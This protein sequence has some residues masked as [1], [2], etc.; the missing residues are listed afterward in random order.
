MQYYSLNAA[1]L[2]AAIVVSAV[3]GIGVYLLVV[4][5][6]SWILRHERRIDAGGR[7]TMD[8]AASQAAG[9]PVVE[10]SGVSKVFAASGQG[11]RPR[12]GPRRHRPVRARR[13]VH[14][15]DRAVGLRQVH[16]AADRGRPD[17]ADDGLR[18]RERQACATGPS[19]PGLRDGLPGS[20]PVRLAVRA[21]Q[22]RAA[23]RDQRHVQGGTRPSRSGAPGARRAVRLRR[24]TIP[25]SC[26]AAC[27]S[28]S[29]SHARSRSI[30]R[31]C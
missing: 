9:Q 13:R 17:R 10:I 21:G 14:L 11:A 7:V 27:S 30:R 22:R 23:A 31:S 24:A 6:E 28:G 3:L 15:A 5:V 2:W 29:P 20:D 8:A 1:F 16:P 4:G 25:G 19:R 26:R 18:D 12:G